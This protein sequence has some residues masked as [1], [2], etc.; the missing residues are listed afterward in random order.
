MKT[1]VPARTTAMYRSQQAA[2]ARFTERAGW[3]VADV[4]TSIEEESAR[5]RDGVALSDV[6]ACG[7]L[8]VRGEAVEALGMKLTGRTLPPAGRASRER[9]NGA[10]VLVCRRAADEVLLLTA[11]AEHP[12]VADLAVRSVES[13]GCVHLTDLT[14]AFAIVDVMGPGLGTLLERVVPLDLAAVPALGL[15][16]GE[17]AH[18]NV[19]MVRLDYPTL[20]VFRVLVPREYGDFVWQ[21]LTETGRDLGVTPIG[22]AAHARL[23]SHL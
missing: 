1:S 15:V 18:V 19:L 6:S 4:Y 8:A 7:K 10:S 13:A 3:R 2:G 21:T 9:V 14:A 22:A 11:A 20:A 12:V 5:A 17:L 23:M 16:Q